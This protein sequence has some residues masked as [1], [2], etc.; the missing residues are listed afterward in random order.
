MCFSVTACQGEGRIVI[1]ADAI[2]AVKTESKKKVSLVGAAKIPVSHHLPLQ[3]CIILG[4]QI[5]SPSRLFISG[6]VPYLI[7][8]TSLDVCDSRSGGIL[9]RSVWVDE[10][11]IRFL[12]LQ[13]YEHLRL[14][15]SYIS[16]IVVLIARKRTQQGINMV[17]SIFITSQKKECP[18]SQFLV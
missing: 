8:A 9:D 4:H 3:N 18:N 2:Q 14:T 17:G 5:T 1:Q 15:W 13:E 7:H 12:L 16:E 11:H 10:N 6:S